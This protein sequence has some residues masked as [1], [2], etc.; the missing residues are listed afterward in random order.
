MRPYVGKSGRDSIRDR[1]VVMHAN[2]NPWTLRFDA[3]ELTAVPAASG[4]VAR[5]P[6]IDLL[7][8][9]PAHRRFDVEFTLSSGPPASV[10]VF[11]L[12]GRVMW[13]SP[14]IFAAAGTHR[15]T[16]DLGGSAR[17]GLYF[18]RVTQGGHAAVKRVAVVD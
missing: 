7:K 8:P 9:N 4:R 6:R 2:G 17:A 12:A 13:K 16:V 10:Q 18:V 3:P 14:G 1:M 5:M 11:D 15:A